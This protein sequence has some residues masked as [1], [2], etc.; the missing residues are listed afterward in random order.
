MI[1]M[2]ISLSF[3][4]NEK[5]VAANIVAIT[6]QRCFSG[7]M[8]RFLWTMTPHDSLFM[9]SLAPLDV[10]WTGKPHEKAVP[11]WAASEVRMSSPEPFTG[12]KPPKCSGTCEPENLSSR[13]I[14]PS[15]QTLNFPGPL[16]DIFQEP[17]LET[18]VL[19]ENLL[20]CNVH[21]PQLQV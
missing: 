8:Q 15:L 12:H 19:A 18:N 17:I 5:H 10:H 6:P 4:A 16:H 7:L 13:T 1:G 2:P 20:P 14:K 3:E 9:H 11:S 21:C